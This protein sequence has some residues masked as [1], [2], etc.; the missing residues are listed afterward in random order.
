MIPQL[1]SN[2]KKKL[3]AWAEWEVAGFVKEKRVTKHERSGVESIAGSAVWEWGEIRREERRS[4]IKDPH[5]ARTSSTHFTPG[6]ALLLRRLTGHSSGARSAPSL[7]SIWTSS[8]REGPSVS[9]PLGEDMLPMGKGSEER[10]WTREGLGRSARQGGQPPFPTG[11][12][13]AR[14]GLSTLHSGNLLLPSSF[15]SQASRA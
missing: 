15:C 2:G 11:S 8:S 6:C 10:D 13:A 9:L 1:G 5:P 3:R 4:Q 12:G 14:R 7:F